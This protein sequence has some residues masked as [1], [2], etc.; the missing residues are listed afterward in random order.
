MFPKLRSHPL[1]KRFGSFKIATTCLLLLI[2]LTFFGTFY[3]IEHGL[4]LAQEKFFYS[5]LFKWML[6]VP[7][8]DFQ[9]WF[10]FPGGLL[11]CTVL[12]I[13]L[14]VATIFKI[15][16]MKKKLGVLLI[17]IGLITLMLGSGITFFMAEESQIT[18]AEGSSTEFAQSYSEWELSVWKEKGD[19][20]VEV[21]AFDLSSKSP[22]TLVQF[23]DFNLSVDI[24]RYYGN[25]Q[26]YGVQPAIPDS[27][28]INSS[29][30]AMI[31]SVQLRKSP[32]SNL[33]GGY[34]KVKLGDQEQTLLLFASE[35]R[36]TL[37]GDYAFQL[38]RRRIPLPFQI[39]LLDFQREM[40]GGTGMAKSY[41][42]KVRI[43]KQKEERDVLIWMNHPL[44]LDGFTLFQSSFATDPESGAELSTFATVTNP[45]RLIPY[46]STVVSG[47]GL[48]IHFI[49]ALIP[50]LG[51]NRKRKT[52]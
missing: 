4:Y 20:V 17:H 34:F 7:G 42:S 22:G 8:T 31:R 3:Q 11:V 10:P 46:I 35:S 16:W 41:Q 33:P 50:Q 36:A 28:Y 13:N 25:S 44:R 24:L 47:L 52:S 23:S 26:P 29:G 21:S 14:I 39:T 9:F 12:T 45:G 37:V 38:R 18:L 15:V 48:I 43:I 5:W 27:G 6:S 32:E 1:V 40:H 49:L 19:S 30:I 51:Q 2:V